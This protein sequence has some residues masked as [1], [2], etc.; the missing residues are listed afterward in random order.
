MILLTPQL[1]E[2]VIREEARRHRIDFGSVLNVSM[3][4]AAVN[5]RRAAIKRLS[6][7]TQ[8][9][10][11]ELAS[12]WGCETAT[13]RASLMAGSPPPIVYDA[14]TAERL[15]WAHGEARAAVI[16]AGADPMTRQDIAAWR[17]IGGGA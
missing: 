12:V 16:I 3:R 14:L 15:R 2:R 13:I 8:C 11:H 17:A 10:P 9:R 7:L 4:S 5:A 6:A 1:V